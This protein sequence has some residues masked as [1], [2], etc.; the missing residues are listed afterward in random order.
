VTSSREDFHLQVDAHAGRTKKKS[1]AEAGLFSDDLCAA[2]TVPVATALATTLS[3]TLATALSAAGLTGLKRLIAAA[4]TL[5]GA[6][7][8]YG[9]GTKTPGAR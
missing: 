6:I 9:S 2:L 7:T 3:A 1:P 8:E 5:L 4:G